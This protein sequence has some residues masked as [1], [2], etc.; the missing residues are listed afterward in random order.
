MDEE[1]KLSR[2]YLRELDESGNPTGE[3]IEVEVLGVD[4]TI[5]HENGRVSEKEKISENILIDP[6]ILE[7]MLDVPHCETHHERDGVVKWA[8]ECTHEVVARLTY[9][10]KSGLICQNTVNGYLTLIAHT[11]AGCKRPIEE[12]W[13]VIPYE[14]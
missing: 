9:H 6:H 12:C 1:K 13:E 5:S 3:I 2:V 11:C 7:E 4:M 14:G 8:G 10:G